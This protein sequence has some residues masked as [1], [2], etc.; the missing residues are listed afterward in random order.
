MKLKIKWK[1]L[2]RFFRR[3]DPMK[4]KNFKFTKI[5]IIFLFFGEK[6]NKIIFNIWPIL[7]DP[8]GIMKKFL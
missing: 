6:N 4:L 2:I 3:E 5:L 1:F 7:T 8:L